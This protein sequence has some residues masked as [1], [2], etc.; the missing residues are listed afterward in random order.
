MSFAPC[1]RLV[2][3]NDD[4]C[5]LAVLDAYA[6]YCRATYGELL[7]ECGANVIAELCDLL[8]VPPSATASTLGFEFGDPPQLHPWVRSVV[9]RRLERFPSLLQRGKA[10]FSALKPIST[11]DLESVDVELL[12]AYMQGPEQELAPLE[13]HT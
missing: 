4:A 11:T 8:D 2:F 3:S 9:L 5:Y 10:L 12:K 6:R 13:Q 1:T 7:T